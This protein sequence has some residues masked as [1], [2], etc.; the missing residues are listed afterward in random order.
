MA[1]FYRKEAN[2]D[3]IICDLCPRHC[4]LIPN[5]RGFC[6]VRQNIAGEMVL[7]TYGKTSGIA[8]DPI[9]KK[10]LNHF[11]PGSDILSFG[12]AGCNLGC[13]Y[14]QNWD[15]SRAKDQQRLSQDASPSDI[16]DIAIHNH[17][18]SIAYT[19]NDPIIFA[20][21]AIDTA[22]LAQKNDV[23]NV[24]VS[25]G[26]ISKTA[27]EDF[28]LV[29]DAANIDL[30]AFSDDFYQRY[31][32]AHLKPVLETLKWIRKHTSVW[33]EITTLVIPGLNDSSAEIHALAEFVREELGPH[34]PLHLSA[35]A[36]NYKLQH[37]NRTSK[38][39]LLRA[40]D[41]ARNAGLYHVYTG[42]IIDENSQ[43][44]FC[45]SCEQQLIHRSGYRVDKRGL[46]HEGRCLACKT[47]LEGV[48]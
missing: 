9:E 3:A 26:Y 28:F 25:A 19:Y 39:D 36:P 31:C 18:Q 32:S 14:C 43:S 42:N 23:K 24:A 48:F 10:P 11:L 16:V 15:I 41:I 21:Y 2:S 30:K 1:R 5:K 33:L 47:K 29:M 37:I 34:T 20:E 38:E 22:I 44:T 7:T 27:R 46:D 12:T 13:I 8:V 40:R 45:P 17:C 6:F 4:R 35:F